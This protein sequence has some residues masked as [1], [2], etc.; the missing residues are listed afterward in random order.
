[1]TVLIIC[2]QR[3]SPLACDSWK[4]PSAMI[5]VISVTESIAVENRFH[6][7]FQLWQSASNDYQSLQSS[8]EIITSAVF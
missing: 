4:Q 1:M 3:K 8:E 7:I 6:N 2:R 5:I